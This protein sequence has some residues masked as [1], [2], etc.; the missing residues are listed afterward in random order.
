MN[1]VVEL[2]P[3]VFT[4]SAIG[5]TALAL[6]GTSVP[7]ARGSDSVVVRPFLSPS[8]SSSNATDGMIAASQP[9][10][11]VAAVASS[12]HAQLI[13]ELRASSSFTWEQTA[14]LFG[15]SRR[16]VHLWAAGGNMA[17]QNEE[18]LA[19]LLREVRSIRA[20]GAPDERLQ[21]L[22]MLDRERY[23]RA[24]SDDDINRPASIYA[25]GA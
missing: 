5:L 7:V 21:L 23:G 19:E 8:G 22:A 14:K 24:S 25:A 13:A 20:A 10:E 17:S 11:T 15:V 9:A 18:H 3:R 16:T 2:S 4:L 1:G 12:S 6:L